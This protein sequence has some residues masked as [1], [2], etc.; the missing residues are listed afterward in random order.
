VLRI[1]LLGASAIAPWALVEPASRRGGDVV[2]QAVASRDRERAAAFART[3]GISHVADDYAALVARGDIDVVYNALPPAL[4]A[5]WSI[6]ALQ[7]GKAVLCE[8]PLAMSAAQAAAM[9]QAAHAAGRPLWEALHYRFHPAWLALCDSC[10]A[11]E[12]GEL[13]SV[14]AQLDVRIERREG[15]LRWQRSLG[16]GV[17]MDLGCYAVH[18]LRTLLGDPCQ[19]VEAQ[20]QTIEGVDA[21][22]RARLVGRGGVGGELACSMVDGEYISSLVVTGTRGQWRFDSFAC[23][24]YQGRLACTVDGA[25]ERELAIDPRATYD[26]QLDHVVAHWRGA[27]DPADAADSVANATLIEALQQQSQTKRA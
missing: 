20:A 2:V 27:P 18:A 3:H 15:E 19:V 17:L 9:F 10:R 12:I 25:R 14:E 6:A 24:H 1:G 5:T 21:R 8:K 16:G 23:A 7:A 22:V 13:V 26:W 4:H 11:G